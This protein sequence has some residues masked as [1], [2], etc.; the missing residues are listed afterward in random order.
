MIAIRRAEEADLPSIAAIQAACPE[1]AVWNPE[2]YLAYDLFAAECDGF[3]AGYLCARQTAPGEREILNIAVEPG[4]RRLGVGRALLDSY[5][6]G[7]RGEVFLE[8]RMSNLGA[9]DFYKSIGF[10]RFSI[11]SEYY[12]HPVEDGV[13]MRL[14]SC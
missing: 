4:S 2:E 9:M 8:V 3:V 12:D 6:K 7:F 14:H 11:R 13:V 1:S 10:Q 5:L